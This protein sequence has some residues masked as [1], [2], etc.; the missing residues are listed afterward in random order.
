MTNTVTAMFETRTAMEECLRKL[1]LVGITENQIGVVMSDTTRGKYFKI[2]S[3]SKAD[4][5]VAAGATF[6]GIVGGVLTALLGVG[7][8]AIP[9]LNMVVAGSIV[10]GLVGA[11]VGA[12]AGG[13]AGGLIGLGI[14][15]HEAKLY[16]S[17]LK[18]G[19]ILLAVEARDHEQAKQVRG[20]MKDAEAFNIAA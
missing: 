17:G 12:A 4:E 9:G 20:I 5:G 10:A 16:E 15:E 1:E 13:L 7:T 6:G 19:H 2:E 11:S 8:M 18:S 14:T 3:H